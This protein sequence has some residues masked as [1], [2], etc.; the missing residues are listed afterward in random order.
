MFEVN[1][2]NVQYYSD[3][4]ETR[5]EYHTTSVSTNEKGLVATPQT[6]VFHFRTQRKVSY[7]ARDTDH[8]ARRRTGYEATALVCL[9]KRSL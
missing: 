4:I 3:R 6:T 5:Y 7:R 9:E 2:S 8:L 1:S